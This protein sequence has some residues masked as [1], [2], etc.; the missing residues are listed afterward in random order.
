MTIFGLLWMI[1]ILISMLMPNLNA[2]IFLTLLSSTIQCSNVIVMG[3]SGIGPQV[4]TSAAFVIKMLIYKKNK[5]IKIRRDVLGIQLGVILIFAMVL[6]SSC[7]NN[8]LLTNSLRIMQL[9]TY[10]LCFLVMYN[11]GESV[12]I[13][14]VYKTIRKM[15]I[16]LLVIGIVQ[17]SITT[18][19]LPRFSIIQMILYN[20]NLSDAI[21]FTRNNYF[22]ILST[23]ME[24]SYY[25]GF[26]VGA[27]YYFLSYKEKRQEN[28]FLLACILLEIIFTFSSTAYGAFALIGIIFF[29]SSKEGKLKVFILVGGILGIFVMYFGFYD[30]L[31]NVI[32]SKMASG[33]GVA[34]YYWNV[35]AQKVFKSS[36]IYGTGYKTSRASSLF[37]TLLAEMG[38]LGFMAYIFTNLHIILSIFSKKRRQRLTKEYIGICLAV[39]SVVVCQM[40]AV[41]DLDICTYWMWMN[42]LALIYSANKRKILEE[43]KCKNIKYTNFGGKV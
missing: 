31:D 35:A 23:Y 27:F 17:I 26:L 39:L 22:R 38:I 3:G 15:T 36:P 28:L 14:F 6:I 18:G 43:N 12:D 13:E 32:F 21:Y 42:F 33:S 16:F 7:A 34:R 1:L 9:L 41:P 10:I 24:P 40:I 29:A 11:A 4:I 20:D 25:A 8:T 2:M 37:Y 30:I 5:K 19:I